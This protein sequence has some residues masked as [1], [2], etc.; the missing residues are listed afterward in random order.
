MAI[1]KLFNWMN[2]YYVPG[3]SG[4]W[5]HDCPVCK[6]PD[7]MGTASWD[8]DKK[9]YYIT[10]HCKCGYVYRGMRKDKDDNE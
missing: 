1:R 2:Q 8:Y 5:S 6:K 7:M 9:D 4:K 3:C 10:E